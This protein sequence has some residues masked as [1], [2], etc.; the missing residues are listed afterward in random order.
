MYGNGGMGSINIREVQMAVDNKIIQQVQN[1]QNL[2]YL[3]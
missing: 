2:G 3:M 1:V